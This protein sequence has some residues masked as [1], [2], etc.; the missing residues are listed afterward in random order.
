MMI[1]FYIYLLLRNAT[2][3]DRA[4][5]LQWN[6]DFAIEVFGEPMTNAQYIDN[7]IKQNTIYLWQDEVPVSF[8]C[9]AGSTPNGKRLGPV[10]TPKEYRKKG[11]ATTCVADLSQKFLEMGCKSCFLFTDLANPISNH[12][13]RKIGYLPVTDCCEYK[14]IN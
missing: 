4:L 12:I 10:Y 3:V 13:Y 9:C 2:E 1:V 11:Y 7:H 8:V 5:L 14:I 6:Q